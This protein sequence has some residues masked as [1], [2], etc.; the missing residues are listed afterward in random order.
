MI[1]MKEFISEIE[2]FS[3][4]KLEVLQQFA[5]FL[6]YREIVTLDDNTYLSSIPGMADSIKEGANTPLS[7]CIPIAEVWPDV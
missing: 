1:A 6:K 2:D 3:E 5:Y 4:D 7:E